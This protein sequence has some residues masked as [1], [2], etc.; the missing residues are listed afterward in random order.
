MSRFDES[1]RP[2][3]TSCW[4]LDDIG[5]RL[6]SSTAFLSIFDGVTYVNNIRQSGQYGENAFVHL[7]RGRT[8]SLG[9]GI[10]HRHRQALHTAGTR[11]FLTLAYRSRTMCE[12]EG[13]RYL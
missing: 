2:R 10:L 9:E 4:I 7:P 3:S 6:R 1:R 13:G 5:Y 8:Y 11:W 12:G